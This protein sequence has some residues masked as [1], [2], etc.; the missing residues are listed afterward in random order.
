MFKLVISDFRRIFI[1]MAA[2]ITAIIFLSVISPSDPGILLL[3]V[4]VISGAIFLTYEHALL[5][6]IVS[7]PFMPIIPF[8]SDS[9]SAWRLFVFILAVRFIYSQKKRIYGFFRE[10]SYKKIKD[11]L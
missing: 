9:F 2:Q 11:R 10:I 4:F 3:D 1:L 6:F 7:L 8:V 5:F